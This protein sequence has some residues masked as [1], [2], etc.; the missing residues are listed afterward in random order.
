MV[1]FFP[2]G[3]REGACRKMIQSVESKDYEK[4]GKQGYTL[5]LFGLL[6][7]KALPLF[8]SLALDVGRHQLR[9]GIPGLEDHQSGPRLICIEQKGSQVSTK[10]KN[11]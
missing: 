3:T 5:Y 8:F 4:G 9:G 2:H 11:G 10:H 7:D 6:G 1:G